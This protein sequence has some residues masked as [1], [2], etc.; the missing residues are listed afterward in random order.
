MQK[1]S[2][3]IL[4]KIITYTSNS[5]VVALN[6]RWLEAS[7]KIYNHKDS[8]EKEILIRLNIIKMFKFSHTLG[9]SYHLMPFVKMIIKN[10]PDY[11]LFES[12]MEYKQLRK[13]LEILRNSEY[14][15]KIGGDGIRMIERWHNI[16]GVPPEYNEIME[17]YKNYNTFHVLDEAEI[18]NSFLLEMDLADLIKYTDETN[19]K[20]SIPSYD[21]L[22]R[23]DTNLT[24]NEILSPNPIT[25]SEFGEETLCLQVNSLIDK[26]TEDDNVEIYGRCAGVNNF[27]W[28]R[29]TLYAC[30]HCEYAKYNKNYVHECDFTIYNFKIIDKDLYKSGEDNIEYISR[31]HY[32]LIQLIAI[33]NSE[34]YCDKDYKTINDDMEKNKLILGS[35]QRYGF[36]IY[37]YRHGKSFI[38]CPRE[39]HLNDRYWKSLGEMHLI[40]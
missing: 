32:L 22:D 35:A 21:I 8:V 13:A 37:H 14:E 30:M 16:G 4:S 2:I 3:P 7:T 33:K 9:D 38:N 1:L 31:R 15:K 17:K 12:G 27:D 25:T 39:R 24:Q 26:M 28:F 11:D 40:Q 18:L 20:S 23:F 29:K 34:Y 10:N 36:Y 5:A 19:S 6:S